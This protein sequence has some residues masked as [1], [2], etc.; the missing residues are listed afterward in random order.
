MNLQGFLLVLLTA[1]LTAVANLLL[2][3]GI[4][5]YGEFSLSLENAREQ[6]IALSMQPMFVSG[7]FLY[8]LAAIVWFSVLSIEDISTSYPMLVGITFVLVAMGAVW[9]FDEGVSWQKLFGMM[10]ILS[11]IVAIARA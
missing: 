6:F 7:V 11:G 8:G 1:L 3:G 2:R 5:Q 10:L 4:L 9:F